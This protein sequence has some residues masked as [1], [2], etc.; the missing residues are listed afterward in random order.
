MKTKQLIALLNQYHLPQPGEECDTNVIRGITGVSG[1][2]AQPVRSGGKPLI[3]SRYLPMYAAAALLCIVCL[4]MM[5]EPSGSRHTI[6][7]ESLSNIY[8]QCNRNSSSMYTTTTCEQNDTSTG[9]TRNESKSQI[10]MR[11]GT[12][13]IN[14]WDTIR[15]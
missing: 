12:I 3:L 5:R 9:M 10:S 1:L 13:R 14:T 6:G 7:L 2:R 15:R 4:T 11:D 8:G